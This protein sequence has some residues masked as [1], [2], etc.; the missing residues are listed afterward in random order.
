MLTY[1]IPNRR[2]TAL[3]V[4]WTLC[5]PLASGDD[6]AA[7]PTGKFAQINGMEM[8][9]EIHGEG[10]PLVLLHGFFGS[11]Q[12]WKPLLPALTEEFQVILPDLRN[13][14]RTTNPS[15]TF[16]HRQ[17]AKDVYALLDRL[18]IKKFRA[19]GF[20]TGGMTLLHMATSQPD[21][22]KAM[23]L[24]GASTYLPADCRNHRQLTFDIFSTA[25]E[26]APLM[27]LHVRGGGQVR[28]LIAL[29]HSFEDSFDDMNFTPPYLSTIRASTLIIQGDRDKYFPI[30]IAAEMHRSI[31]NSY[32]WIVPNGGHVPDIENSTWFAG[33]ILEFLRG[34]W[35]K[36][37]YP[38]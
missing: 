17:A 37:N 6:D 28:E 11:G 18:G 20:S 34:E 10:E 22:V 2:W 12:F 33:P 32:L 35:E 23:V 26:L 4:A 30:P 1:K 29:W 38:R 14:G 16:T 3:I 21:R 19:M 31:P 27:K 25:P 9:Y 7:S 24:F 15:K 13:H 5:C 36:N 8:Y